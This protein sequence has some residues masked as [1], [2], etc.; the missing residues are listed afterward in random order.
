M[1]KFWHTLSIIL[2]GTIVLMI[3]TTFIVAIISAIKM[4]LEYLF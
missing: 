2:F 1:R 3:T 4:G